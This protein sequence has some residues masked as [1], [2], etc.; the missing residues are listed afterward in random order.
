MS[1]EPSE[2]DAVALQHARRG[3]ALQVAL[4][5][6][7]VGFVAL[8]VIAVPPP[9][10]VGI[11]AAIAGGYALWALAVALWT[12]R[13]HPAAARMAWLALLVDVVVLGVLTLLTG[14]A[15]PQSWTSDVFT[16][17][18]LLI[19]VLAATQ[20]RVWVCTAVVV[21]TAAVYFLAAVA[22]REANV[23][24][25]TSLLLRTLVMVGV[26]LGLSLIHI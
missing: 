18:F 6:V 2:V 26:A 20:L 3:V 1:P 16:T 19:P 15:T 23:E 22:T 8:T 5:W 25:W 21:P 7:L 13:R 4:R 9:R 12:R 11:C 10:F 17:G 24:P 14:V